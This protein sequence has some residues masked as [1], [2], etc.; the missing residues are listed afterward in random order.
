MAEVDNRSWGPSWKDETT[1]LFAD[2]STALFL[3][4][5]MLPACAEDI[6][7]YDAGN[8]GEALKN[9]AG[10]AYVGLVGVF[11]IRVLRRRAKRA[12]E[13]VSVGGGNEDA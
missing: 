2:V 5:G 13:E 9:A 4:S 12:R 1:P 3:V 8:G 10:V 6:V 7:K 11:L